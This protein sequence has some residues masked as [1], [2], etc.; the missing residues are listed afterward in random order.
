METAQ[1]AT[2][3]NGPDVAEVV[4][5]DQKFNLKVADIKSIRANP[6]ALRNVN[7]EEEGYITIRESMR[8][9]GILSPISVRQKRDAETGDKYYELCDGLQRFTAAKE[10][11][12]STFPINI[13]DLDD[14]QVLEAQMIGNFARVETKSV[15]YQQQLKRWLMMNPM[16]T[17]S[18]LATRLSRSTQW[19]EKMLALSK[20]AD[21]GIKSL[22]DSGK[23]KISNAF[24]MTKLS[25]EDQKDFV[26]W[27]VTEPETEFAARVD[28]RVKEVRAAKKTGGDAAPPSFE[29][30]AYLRKISEIQE[31]L[32]SKK[33]AKSLVKGDSE[34]KGF[35][36]GLK[37]AMHL[38]A[39][40]IAEAKA[41][42]EA[43]Q[44]ELN[45]KR[46]K[47]DAEGLAR[48]QL[49]AFRLSKEAANTEAEIKGEKL[50]F[51]KLEDLVAAESARLGIVKKS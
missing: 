22:I 6:I 33:A 24:H 20:V 2:Q 39:P 29:A 21:A 45:E 25:S 47:R 8:S 48:K 18:D 1:E 50:P 44:K 4:K 34:I 14:T 15:Q 42:F 35:V 38:D 31:E 16:A 41:K 13:K 40:A 27:A 49:K 11:G 9:V 3:S 37:W 10:L 23:I 36:E 43:S 17:L 12:W 46:A 30:R 7:T 19:L 26:E 32:A 5:A 28:A 51:P